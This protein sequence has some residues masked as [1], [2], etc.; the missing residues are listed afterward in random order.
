MRTKIGEHSGGQYHPAQEKLSKMV[1][2][3]PAMCYADP[4]EIANACLFLASDE[5]KL[6]NGAELS[7][8]MGMAVC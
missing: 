6:I 7:V 8:D 5:A 2:A 3:M 4:V 1:A